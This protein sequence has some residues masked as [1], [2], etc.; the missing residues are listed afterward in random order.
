MVLIS[1]RSI[2]FAA[3]PDDWRRT[4]TNPLR[5][6]PVVLATD[7]TTRSGALVVAA[8]LLATKL[9]L[10][11]E[12]I[13]V[14]EPKSEAASR[15][16]GLTTD[17]PAVEDASRYA[18][19]IGVSDYVSRF[20][21]GAT[22]PRIHVRVGNVADEI[23]RFA[24]QVSATIVIIGAMP[25]LLLRRT[26]SA[27]HVTQ[28]LRS[29]DCP[30][31]TV[32]P[33]FRWLPR[34]VV[35]AVDFGPSSVRAAQAALLLVDRGGTL[36]LAHVRPT[37]VQPASMSADY[38]ATDLDVDVHAL[39][40]RVRDEL[41]PSIPTGVKIETVLIADDPADGIF[42]SAS[43]ARAELIAVGTD[44]IG[45]LERL[46]LGR[47]TETVVRDADQAVLASPPPRPAEAFDLWRRV[48][49]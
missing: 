37:R 25:D 29:I 38:R 49:A 4:P 47:V 26:E 31:L 20:A 11:L 42:A 34:V 35:A 12:V 15:T 10:P 22:P 2:P 16:A 8:Q 45:A 40:D 23:A 44:G 39:F 18:R 43:H 28:L 1:E 17:D 13:S 24:R 46:L 9:D 41:A 14:L 32:P 5:R 21:G 19:E 36:L 7:G 3:V 6:G 30:V 27:A 33:S 48:R